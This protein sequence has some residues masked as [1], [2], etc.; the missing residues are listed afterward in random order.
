MEQAAFIH[1][2]QKLDALLDR[3]AEIK[4]LLQ[5]RLQESPPEGGKGLFTRLL[6]LPLYWQWIIGG[7][8]SWGVSAA[9][10]SYLKNGGDPLKLIELLLGLFS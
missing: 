2:L 5:Q 1:L 4:A 8:V 7:I 9:I 10:G 6:K 3:Q